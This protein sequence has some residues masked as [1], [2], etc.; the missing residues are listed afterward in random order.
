MILPSLVLLALSQSTG[1]SVAQADSKCG[2]APGRR[3]E[4]LNAAIARDQTAAQTLEAMINGCGAAGAVCETA[5]KA[6]TA[7]LSTDAKEEAGFDEAA[8]VKD[9]ETV[10]QGQKFAL[11]QVI[12]AINPLTAVTVCPSVVD[13]KVLLQK[14]NER[15]LR[16]K[17][18]ATEYERFLKWG[19]GLH[20][21]CAGTGPGASVALVPANAK[22]AEAA[23]KAEQVRQSSKAAEQKAAA[24]AA[25]AAEQL[26][27]E[28]E[29]VAALKRDQNKSAEQMKAEQAKTMEIFNAEQARARADRESAEK[30]ARAAADSAIAA[31]KETE[32][33]AR[34]ETEAADKAAQAAA[35]EALRAQKDAEEKAKKA[36]DDAA[37][38]KA[39]ND[40]KLKK[41]AEETEKARKVAEEKSKRAQDEAERTKKEAAA[42]AEKQRQETESRAKKEAE[43]SERR[44]KAEADKQKR[45][46]E[47]NAQREKEKVAAEAQRKQ[48][49]KTV[50]TRESRKQ[51]IRKKK[52][53]LMAE[54]QA[55]YEKAV[56]AANKSKAVAA[57]AVKENPAAA[58]AL[59]AQAASDQAAVQ[60]AERK[61][62]DAKQQADALEVDESDERSNGSLSFMLGAGLGSL[63][64]S[65]GSAGGFGIGLMG[66]GHLGFW[67]TA[68]AQGMASGFEIRASGRFFNALGAGAY[69]GFD[70]LATARYFIGRFGVGAGLEGRFVNSIFEKDMVSSTR[71]EQLPIGVGLSLGYQFIDT[72]S[73]RFSVNAHYTP[74]IS[75]DWG[76]ISGDVE[77][78]YRAFTLWIVGGTTTQPN[79][80]ASGFFLQG[81]AGIRLFF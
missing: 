38:A 44:A 35:D 66:V 29:R 2:V 64:S 21:S 15:G 8:Y 80:S 4:P 79:A 40:L 77:F 45:E 65:E 59:V 76:R 20:A 28:Q 5:K 41:Q 61:V 24:D 63:I 39:S 48:D 6:C 68:P 78:S 67:G 52:E 3:I 72:P 37:K 75:F 19:E 10:Y 46:A 50:E 42:R 70:G 13:A 53:L 11:S 22:A 1:V 47:E 51:E 81:Y 49:E 18:L 69:R 26:K 34:K 23:Q 14:R 43:E 17:V 33:R 73:T 58:Q 74:I 7:Q 54:P 62:F 55:N 57:S 12:A 36:A 30:A 32:E 56:D 16:R 71:R 9:F 27:A 60:A 25:K 31:Q